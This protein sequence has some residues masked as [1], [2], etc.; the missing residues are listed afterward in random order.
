MIEFKDKHGAIVQFPEQGKLYRVDMKKWRE[1]W[2]ENSPI[3]RLIEVKA[4]VTT[5]R[6]SKGDLGNRDVYYHKVVA[7]VHPKTA[8]FIFIDSG[9]MENSKERFHRV[10]CDEVV[11]LIPDYIPLKLIDLEE[12]TG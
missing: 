6:V 4:T 11:G 7:E 8:I 10:I 1:K 12:E 3:P 9:T 5:K 2:V